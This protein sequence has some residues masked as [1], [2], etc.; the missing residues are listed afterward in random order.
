MEV[1]LERV[2]CGSKVKETNGRKWK[3]PIGVFWRF[4]KSE[5]DLN[6]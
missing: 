3:K 1:I 5:C 6:W 2:N 4:G